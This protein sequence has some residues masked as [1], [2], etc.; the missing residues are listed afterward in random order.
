M[1][2]EKPPMNADERRSGQTPVSLA[3]GPCSWFFSVSPCLRGEFLLPAAAILAIFLPGCGGSDKPEKIVAPT[4]H[5]FSTDMDPKLAT[6]TYW[7]TQPA[8]SE[9]TLSDFKKLW[10]TCEAVSYDYLFKISRRDFRSGILT[11]EPMLSKQWF[12]LWRK[13]GP[14]VKD[15]QEASLGGIRRTIYFQFT[16]NPDGSYTVAPKVLVERESKLERKYRTG[17]SDEATTYWYALRRDSEMEIRI[18]AAL[19]EKLGIK[20]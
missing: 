1:M 6:P 4:T 13:D 2:R 20:S 10:D 19:R 16:Q 17:E 11:T 9:L 5:P 15:V 7:L 12:E 18:V 8:A 14:K 3:S